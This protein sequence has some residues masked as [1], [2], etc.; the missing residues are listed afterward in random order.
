M[1]LNIIFKANKNK[2]KSRNWALYLKNL[3][4]YGDYRESSRAKSQFLKKFKSQNLAQF[5]RLGSEFLRVI[6]IFI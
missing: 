5:L 3:A 1:L 6:S 2:N 4:S